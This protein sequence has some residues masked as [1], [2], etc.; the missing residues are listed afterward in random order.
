MKIN[1]FRSIALI[2]CLSS[3]LAFGQ[4]AKVQTA[5]N[6]YK[7]PYQQFDKAK[8]AID[9]AILNESSNGMS[10]TW[11]YRGLIYQSLHGNE[12]YGHLCNNCLTVAF[13]SFKKAMELDP[14][15]EWA[16]EIKMVRFPFLTNSIFQEGV[17]AY[18]EQKYSEA[19]TSFETINR[20]APGDTSVLLNTAFSAERAGQT[21][22][23]IEYYNQLMGMRYGDE[24]VYLSLANVHK[25][26]GDTAK[27][28]EALRTGQKVKPE[29]INLMLSEINIL[30]SSGRNAEATQALDAAIG[31]DP[32]NANLYLALGSTY[33]NLAAPRGGQK[34]KDYATYMAKAN[35]AYNKG[36][37][38]APDNYELNYNMGAFYFNE[39]AEINNQAKDIK[40]N[41]QYE[42][43]KTKSDDKFKQAQPY[44][45]KALEKNPRKTEEDQALYTGTLNSLKQLYVRTN[46]TEKYNQ[47]KQ[48]LEGK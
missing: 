40:D 14:K 42:K 47:V 16:D 46:Q 12:K 18:K 29:S 22:K 26:A 23:A 25:Q 27:A 45:E 31:R 41:A 35:E 34:S 3:G 38:I 44:L 37:T 5:F 10:K 20:L 6:F 11:Y 19:L 17:K 48:M 4:K 7:E 8:E 32:N 36:L 13:E 9:E 33:E 1:Q 30:L 24:K 43:M 28:L 21:A 2:I 15:N 39:G